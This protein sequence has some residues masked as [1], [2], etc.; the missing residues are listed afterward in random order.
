M[1]E[2]VRVYGE[3]FPD[4]NRLFFRLVSNVDYVSMFKVNILNTCTNSE[5]VNSMFE[6]CFEIICFLLQLTLSDLE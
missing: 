5:N 2:A 6:K 1:R 3:K 4:R